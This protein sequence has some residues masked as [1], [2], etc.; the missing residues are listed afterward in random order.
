MHFVF[1]TFNF[2]QQEN[3][4]GLIATI[5]LFLERFQGPYGRNIRVDKV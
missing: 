2:A 4:S 1:L 3:F 5:H